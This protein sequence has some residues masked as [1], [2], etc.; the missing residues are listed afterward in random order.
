MGKPLL[1][2]YL[3]CKILDETLIGIIGKRSERDLSGLFTHI[4]CIYY[5]PYALT[6]HFPITSSVKYQ[7]IFHTSY[8]RYTTHD[9]SVQ[10]SK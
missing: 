9:V 6:V 3:R 4:I 8:S 1:D 10:L 2:P 7:P 5:I